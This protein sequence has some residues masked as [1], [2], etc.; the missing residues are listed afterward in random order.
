M[1]VSSAG[2][3]H[4]IAFIRRRKA[5][6]TFHQYQDSPRGSN[7]HSGKNIKINVGKVQNYR[8]LTPLPPKTAG[9]EPGPPERGTLEG[10]PPCRPI[11]RTF[12]P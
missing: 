3:A 10:R 7:L 6:G 12:S 9:T 11:E 2:G 8:F 5:Y 4:L 1:K